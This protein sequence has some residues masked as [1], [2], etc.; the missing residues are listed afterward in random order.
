MENFAF[1][2]G[3]LGITLST[4]GISA[5]A[6]REHKLGSR[7]TLSDLAAK[8]SKTLKEFRAILWVCGSLI[9]VMM[10]FLV[11]PNISSGSWLLIFYT[12]IIFCELTLAI[13]PAGKDRIGKFHDFLA[14]SKGVGML[15][16]TLTFALILQGSYSVV[17]FIL[18]SIM[19]IFCLLSI[20]FWDYFLFFELPFIFLSHM[21]IL[22]AAIAVR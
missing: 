8:N 9:S 18:L 4:L 6:F 13:I 5:F 12:V 20:K 17:E 2:C 22:L 10:Y 7:R 21:S 14:Y 11:I 16:L 3:I 1:V 19:T 15:A